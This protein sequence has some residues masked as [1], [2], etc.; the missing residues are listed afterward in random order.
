MDDVRLCNKIEYM[1][2]A[3]VNLSKENNEVARRLAS[4]I[5]CTLVEP[6]SGQQSGRNGT[7]DYLF[8][9]FDLSNRLKNKN[10]TLIG[11]MKQNKKEIPMKIK[12]ARQRPEYSS[13]FGFAKE[14]TLMTYVPKKNRS[15][16]LL[17][18]LHNNAVLCY[19]TEKREIIEHY[20]K[21]KGAA[22]TLDKICAGY[23]VQRA[24][25]RWT[26]TMFYGVVNLALVNAFVVYAHNMCK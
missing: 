2:N 21:I 25:W 5:V 17:S 7:T 15:V 8:T 13:L 16:V 12:Y 23:T 9:S 20:N 26:M 18:L 14:F 22:D 11:W 6:I 10:L 1:I 3:K 4:D 24:T 19:D